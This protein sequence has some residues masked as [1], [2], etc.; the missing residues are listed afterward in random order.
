MK[1]Y[2]LAACWILSSIIVTCKQLSH[3]ECERLVK[4]ALMV[5]YVDQRFNSGDGTFP[6]RVSDIALEG[7]IPVSFTSQHAQSFG[8]DAFN[9]SDSLDDE[10]LVQVVHGAEKGELGKIKVRVV[11]AHYE[12][13]KKAYKDSCRK[14]DESFW[15]AV[16]AQH[17]FDL[18]QLDL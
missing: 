7:D 4:K 6:K 10:V 18:L 5:A 15:T 11:R 16:S 13:V 2:L 14:L 1:K 3:N 12:Q 8:R 9:Q 17:W